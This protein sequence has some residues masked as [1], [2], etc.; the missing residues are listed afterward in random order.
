MGELL[1]EMDYV[2]GCET[3]SE[4]PAILIPDGCSVG[5][6][7]MT[8]LFKWFGGFL[9]LLLKHGARIGVYEV[10]E[11]HISVEDKYQVAFVRARAKDVTQEK[12][13]NND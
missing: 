7:S 8:D 9:P 13:N 11:E 3:Y 5:V 4:H 12:E 6:R 1:A 2:H 10:S